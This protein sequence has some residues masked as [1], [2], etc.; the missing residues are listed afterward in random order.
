MRI[1]QE[2]THMELLNVEWEHLVEKVTKNF[3]IS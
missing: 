1:A 2:A 3:T